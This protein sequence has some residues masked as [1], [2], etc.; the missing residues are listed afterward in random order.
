MRGDAE[1]A[2]GP[3]LA[4]SLAVL[5]VAL[6]MAGCAGGVLDPQGPVGVAEKTIL[7]NSLGIML[8]IVIPT[9]VAILGVAWWF[10]AS[11]T[12]AQYRPDW[13][14]S[15]RIEMIVWAIPAMVVLLLGG[16]GWVGS[17][18]LD[19]PKPLASSVKPVN[20]EVVSLDWK[21]LFIYPD[22]GIASV[23]RLV[24]PAGT[25]VS[26]HLT[27]ATVMNSFFVPQLG[28]QIY[29]MAG[30]ATRLNLQADKP[31]SYAGISAQFSGDGFPGMK[32]NYDAV[33]QGQFDGWIAAAKGQGPAL[34][35]AGYGAL[36]R[37]SKNV[38][39]YTYRAVTPGLFES[40]VTMQAPPAETP[41]TGRPNAAVSPRSPASTEN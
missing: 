24:V 33:S 27:S 13:E 29:T 4:R 31:G 14:Y 9:I 30:M 1:D 19:P 5:L 18:D 8:A 22:Q 16:I 20:V 2:G 21:W 35:A 25:P 28:S 34:D 41:H 10:R 26:L 37:E 15:G 32:F 40:I 17:H 12:R 39:P 11:N 38:V 3:P 23:N 6:P 36:A 7:L